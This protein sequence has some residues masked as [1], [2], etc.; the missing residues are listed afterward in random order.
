MGHIKIIAVEVD[1]CP[2][3]YGCLLVSDNGD[4]IVYSG[5]AL[6]CQNLINYAANCKVLI[7]G[8]H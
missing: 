6:P 5:D 4:K 3:S 2:Q 1:H 7:H 8:A